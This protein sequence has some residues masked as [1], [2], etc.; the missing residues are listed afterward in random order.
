MPRIFF[1][2]SSCGFSGLL[3]ITVIV[4][5]R[6]DRLFGRMKPKPPPEH[7]LYRILT[8]TTQEE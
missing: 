3:F 8:F 4:P 7:P 2:V 5:R 1:N 6:Q